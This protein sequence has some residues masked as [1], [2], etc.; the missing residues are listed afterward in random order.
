M[1]GHFIV[2]DANHVANYIFN[3]MCASKQNISK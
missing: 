3:A 2:Y 1:P